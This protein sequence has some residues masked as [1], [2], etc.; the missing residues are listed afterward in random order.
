M[1]VNSNA[2]EISRRNRGPFALFA[3]TEVM[4]CLRFP[5]KKNSTLE[6]ARE[7]TFSCLIQLFFIVVGWFSWFQFNFKVLRFF[8]GHGAEPAD[9]RVGMTT[10]ESSLEDGISEYGIR[11]IKSHKVELSSFQDNNVVV[12]LP[13]QNFRTRNNDE[14]L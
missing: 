2:R 9:Q 12:C 13:S 11:N 14:H 10:I 5:N 8:F 3:P 4:V 6:S 1:S 7:I